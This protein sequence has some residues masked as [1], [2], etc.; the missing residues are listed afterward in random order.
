MPA[1]N[2][3]LWMIER[4]SPKTNEVSVFFSSVVLSLQTLG[5]ELLL[6][7]LQFLGNH[8]AGLQEL[9]DLKSSGVFLH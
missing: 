1:K 4:P 7:F 6:S 8:A 9:F 2:E 3:N 5:C